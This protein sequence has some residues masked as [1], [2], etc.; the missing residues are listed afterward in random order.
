MYVYTD[1]SHIREKETFFILET[2][3]AEIDYFDLRMDWMS[4]QDIFRLQIAVNDFVTMQQDETAQQLLGE[5]ANE[6]Q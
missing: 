4:K 6:L 5:S 1:I 3:G 2:T